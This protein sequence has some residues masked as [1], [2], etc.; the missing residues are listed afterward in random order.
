M[1]VL[2][3]FAALMAL[4]VVAVGAAACGAVAGFFWLA[5][6]AERRL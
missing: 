2:A 6:C 4:L 3:V 5:R 1:I